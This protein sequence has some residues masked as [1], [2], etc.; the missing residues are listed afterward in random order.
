M[1]NFEDNIEKEYHERFHDFEETP[2]DA[3]WAKIQERITPEPERR[4]V[5]FWWQTLRMGIAA[6]VLIGLLLG[7]YYFSTISTN[8]LTQTSNVS[9]KKPSVGKINA[10]KSTPKNQ[11]KEKINPSL[12][13]NFQQQEKK[14]NVEFLPKNNENVA[15]LP[16]NQVLEAI[17]KHEL[18]LENAINEKKFSENVIALKQEELPKKDEVISVETNKNAVLIL[19][20]K[21]VVNAEKL[22]LN[23][24][25]KQQKATNINFKEEENQAILS[26]NLNQNIAFLASKKTNIPQN[27]MSISVPVLNSVEPEIAFE[28]A[29]K[30]RLVFIP[31]S[32]VFVNVTPMLS[33][34]VFSPNKGDN[35]LV[36]NF[37]TSSERLSFAAQLGFVYPIAKKLDLRTGFSFTAGQSKISYGLTN[38]NQKKVTVIDELNIVVQP[39]KS[40]IIENKNWQY[41][42]LQSD[43]LY[44]IKKLH[45]L[46]LGIRAG[47]QTSTLNRP[48]FNGRIGYRVSKPINNRVA[49]WLEPSISFSLSSQSSI[50]NHF[51]YRTTGL[52]LNMGVSLLRH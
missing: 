19:P 29:P 24:E 10:T 33:Y 37:N 22:V 48:L 1:E 13:Q 3:L 32:E 11:E 49:L 4:P 51:L 16:Q 31:P 38:N 35:V 26:K 39:T 34:Y 14:K 30:Q 47:V 2:D 23:N 18:P 17:K 28:V 52:G 41:L 20:E 46:S 12:T 5:V 27:E 50:E 8:T 15:R 6:S 25:V 21:V 45:S 9:L 40:V 7:G 42:E 36:N 44:E 43:L